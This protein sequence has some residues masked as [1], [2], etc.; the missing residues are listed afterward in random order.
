MLSP[1]KAVQKKNWQISNVWVRG[2][3]LYGKIETQ[4][5]VLGSVCLWECMSPLTTDKAYWNWVYISMRV[6]NIEANEN[7]LFNNLMDSVKR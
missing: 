6:S 1:E 5:N 4:P 2:F 7:A 3:D